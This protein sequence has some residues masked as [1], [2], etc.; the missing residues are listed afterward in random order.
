M[1]GGVCPRGNGEKIGGYAAR[2]MD[3]HLCKAG[4]TPL[5]R[6]R[7]GISPRHSRMA[8]DGSI[9][10]GP[11]GSLQPRPYRL[12]LPPPIHGPPPGGV[13]PMAG[14]YG[15]SIPGAGGTWGRAAISG[16][17]MESGAVCYDVNV[18]GYRAGGRPHGGGA[19]IVYRGRRGDYD[20]GPPPCPGR[21]AAV[22]GYYPVPARPTL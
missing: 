18:R 11:G 7:P 3:I 12:T 17:A 16:G 20:G 9:T 19:C 1:P 10:P 15:S 22:Q 13:Y 8:Y 4:Q 2:P 21:G 14:A 6:P 5:L